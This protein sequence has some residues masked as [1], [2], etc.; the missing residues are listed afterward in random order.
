MPKEVAV[1]FK[2]LYSIR[3]KVLL[4]IYVIPLFIDVMQILFKVYV[5]PMGVD[6]RMGHRVYLCILMCL[7]GNGHSSNSF[8]GLISIRGN[9]KAFLKGCILAMSAECIVLGIAD[10]GVMNLITFIGS[11]PKR[12]SYLDFV[13]YGV[14]DIGINIVLYLWAASIGFFIGSIDYRLTKRLFTVFMM[15]V[16][17][18]IYK[19][20]TG[21]NAALNEAAGLKNIFLQDGIWKYAGCIIFFIAIGSLVLYKAPIRTYAHGIGEEG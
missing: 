5:M 21:E 1:Y 12:Q 19:M 17:T 18:I 20:L 10:W 15:V 14:K 13:Y 4:L 9:R 7:I 8:N 6:L 2:N 16:A 3:L 11:L